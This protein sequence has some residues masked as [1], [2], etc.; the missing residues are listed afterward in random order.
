[1]TTSK[2]RNSALPVKPY[3]S[4]SNVDSLF[5]PRSGAPSG[6]AKGGIGKHSTSGL[7]PSV[8][9][10]RQ[11]ILKSTVVWRLTILYKRL[12][13]SEPYLVPHF[14]HRTTFCSCI[15]ED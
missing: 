12:T 3:K 6:K 13:Y 9:S 8:R 11:T 5:Q 7:M 10:V 1:M 15:K 14:M 4:G 2:S